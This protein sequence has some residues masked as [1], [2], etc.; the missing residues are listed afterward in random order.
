MPKSPVKRHK[1]PLLLQVVLIAICVLAVVFYVSGGVGTYEDLPEDQEQISQTRLLL[2]EFEQEVPAAPE[3]FVRAVIE[4]ETQEEE[5]EG[6]E[7]PDLDVLEAELLSHYGDYDYNT[8]HFRYW[9]SDAVI[10]GDSVADAI[11]GFGWLYDQNVQAQGGIGLYSSQEVI[12]NTIS[13][14]PSVVFLTFSANDI[15]AFGADVD[16]YIALYSQ[17]VSEL[18]ESLPNT[19]IYVEGIIPC[20]PDF[21]GEYWYYDY[22]DEYNE[23]LR[24]MCEDMGITYFD[25]SFILYA[26]PDTYNGDGFHPSWEFYPLWLTYMAEIAGLT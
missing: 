5:Q 18:Q 8:D 11:H 25:P 24:K 16:S 4:E 23:A 2:T 10:V 12:D 19:R 17:V 7:K 20:D 26:W 21:R 22:M 9:F 6:S 13:L 1:N 3:T 14:W 15:A